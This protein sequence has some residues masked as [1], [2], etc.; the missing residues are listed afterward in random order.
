MKALTEKQDALLR[1]REELL[2]EWARNKTALLKRPEERPEGAAGENMPPKRM[3]ITGILGELD[4]EL[5]RLDRLIAEEPARQAAEEAT[6]EPAEAPAEEPSPER[7]IPGER[8]GPLQ[9]PVG[10]QSAPENPETPPVQN[11][12]PA[13]EAPAAP[14]AQDFQPM[15]DGLAEKYRDREKPDTF[16]KLLF[17]NPEYR[18]PL[19][20]LQNKAQEV[21]GTTLAQHLRSIGVL[22][23]KTAGS[24]VRQRE[25]PRIAGLSAIAV[26]K[27]E[28]YYQGLNPE[29]YGTFDDA[30]QK[31]EGLVVGHTYGAYRALRRFFV[32]GVAKDTECRANVEIPQGIAFIRQGAFQNQTGLETLALPESLTEIHASAFEGCTGLRRVMLPAGLKLVDSWA[33]GGCAALE[34]V[35]FQGGSPWVDGTVFQGSGYRYTP[36]ENP[37]SS[38][39]RDFTWTSSSGGVVITGYIGGAEK[40]EIPGSIRGLP[41]CGISEGA[42]KGCRSLTEV[43]MPDTIEEIQRGTFAD[44][45]NLQKIHLSN[46]VSGLASLIFC[47]CTALREVN[48]PDRV[49]FLP[50]KVFKDAPLERVHIGKGLETLDT[51]SLG[52]RPGGL[53]QATVDPENRH[54]KAGGPCLY[55]ADGRVLYAFFGEGFLRVPEGVEQIGPG[56]F[57]GRDGLTEVV[58]PSTLRQLGE[59]CFDSFSRDD[60]VQELRIAPAGPW[61]RTATGFTGSTA[62]AK[63]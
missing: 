23:A 62:K 37:G 13:P 29:I 45:V 11:P 35:D 20:T 14:T 25:T 17:E 39:G 53:A 60:T 59:D 61:R 18:G 41:V 1:R 4:A 55:S 49:T 8:E 30:A 24:A 28:E 40:L 19:K 7:E 22:A 44:C 3:R 26:S 5:D 31:L 54:F 52:N 38:D 57:S 58:F 16:G 27:L 47:S 21:F 46:E 43:T 50:Q 42:F 12:R 33:F 63:R 36:P 2:A 6:E 34:E 32:E 51:D 15:L 10:R 48:I 56:A 9:G